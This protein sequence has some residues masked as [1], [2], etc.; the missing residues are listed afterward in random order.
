[1]SARHDAVEAE[2]EAARLRVAVQNALH[3]MENGAFTKTLMVLRNA[4]RPQPNSHNST[5]G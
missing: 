2:A 5:L 1:M 4:A 3:C